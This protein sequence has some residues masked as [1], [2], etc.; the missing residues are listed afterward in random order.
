[1]AKPIG[2]DEFSRSIE[3]ILA[4]VEVAGGDAALEAVYAGLKVG[5]REWRKDAKDSIGKHEYKRNGEVITSGK[6]AKSI[7][8]HMLSRDQRHPSGEIGSKKLAGLT[9]LLEKGH[10]R[11]GGGRVEPVL[12]IAKTVAPAAFE[13]AIAAAQTAI[14][15]G[16]E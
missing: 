11:I 6:Y 1:M 13:A 9:H 3:E 2:V 16:L 4:E 14:M 15:N 7:R 5:S 8:T 10:A 12:H